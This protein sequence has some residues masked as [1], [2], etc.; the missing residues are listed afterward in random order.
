[1]KDALLNLKT[2]QQLVQALENAAQRKPS[3]G[4]LFEQRVSFV[5]SSMGSNTGVTR[6]RVKELVLQHSKG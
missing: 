1:M 2:S 5:Y 6:D 3:V 4:E